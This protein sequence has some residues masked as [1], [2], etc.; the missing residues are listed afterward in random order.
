LQKTE[1]Q[2]FILNS[3]WEQ[4]TRGGNIDATLVDAEEK[5]ACV[6]SVAKQLAS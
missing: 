3:W 1:Q 5:R 2:L 4:K 6:F